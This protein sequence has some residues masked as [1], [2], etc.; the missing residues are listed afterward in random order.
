MRLKRPFLPAVNRV[1]KGELMATILIVDDEVFIRSVAELMVQDLG[2]ETMTA[3]DAA[4]A[5]QH[6]E[7]SKNVTDIGMALELS[8]TNLDALASRQWVNQLAD[9]LRKA[10][11]IDTKMVL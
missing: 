1:G 3:G 6:L 2:H 5:L 8:A 11:S 9:Y 7:S 10:E 4:G